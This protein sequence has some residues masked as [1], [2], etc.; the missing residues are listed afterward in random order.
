MMWTQIVTIVFIWLAFTVGC[1]ILSYLIGYMQ[2]K[3]PGQQTLLDSLYLQ[4]F[5]LM[6]AVGLV[7]SVNF[8]MQEVEHR[9]LTSTILVGYGS[10]FLVYSAWIHFAICGALRFV[11]I[12]S[13]E[14]LDNVP[15]QKIE[16][17]VW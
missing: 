6:I 2:D 3:A 7:L 17:C 1:Y 12:Y 16:I 14:D 5:I 9:S 15:D 8:T 4:L 10:S 11:M 13:P